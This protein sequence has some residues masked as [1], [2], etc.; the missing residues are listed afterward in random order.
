MGKH[1]HDAPASDPDRH[2][3]LA[4]PA[5]RELF[6]RR[7][8][9][10]C[11]KRIDD[12]TGATP[13]RSGPAR[14]PSGLRPG[15][16]GFG[17]AISRL[18]FLLRWRSSKRSRLSSGVSQLFS[19]DLGLGLWAASQHRQPSCGHSTPSFSSLGVPLCRWQRA[20]SRTPLPTG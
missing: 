1:Q 11:R 13:R 18:A 2:P 4:R 12:F 9:E 17:C 14:G 5:C 16:A 20:V 19:R 15:T 8:Y 7:L 10:L 6:A 3:L